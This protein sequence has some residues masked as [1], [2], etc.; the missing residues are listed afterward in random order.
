MSKNHML[1]VKNLHARVAEAEPE[2]PILII[3]SGL[4]YEPVLEGPRSRPGR[5]ADLKTQEV[6]NKGVQ[7]QGKRAPTGP[8]SHME[9]VAKID[10]LV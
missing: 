9:E 3:R 7:S 8:G 5:T 2:K 10:Y 1:E 6:Q 4:D